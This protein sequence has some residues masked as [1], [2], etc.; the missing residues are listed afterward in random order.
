MKK[1][2]VLLLLLFPFLLIAQTTFTSTFTTDLSAYGEL[3][4]Y[5][6]EGEYQIFLS[7]DNILDKPIFLIDGFDPGDSRNITSIYNLLNFTGT[8]GSQNLADLLRAEGFD[9]V[10]L[11]F[12]TYIRMADGATIDGGADFMERNAMVLVELINIINTDKAANSPEQN[13]IIGPSMGGIIA[14]Y[15]LNYMENQSLDADTRLYISFDSPHYGANVPIGLQHQLNFLAYNETSAVAEIQPIINGL[16]NSP[17]AKQLL[18][19]HLEAHLS[20]V[21]L[22]TFN[23][24][25]TLPIAHPFRTVFETNINSLTPSGFPETTRNVSIINGSGINNSYFAVGNTGPTV[26][27]GYS[28]M[29][30]TLNVPIGIFT[31]DINIEVN[32]T[33]AAG[34]TN[35]ASSISIQLFS[36]EIDGSVANSE[37]FS[38][39]DGIDSAP[40]GLFDLSG[41]TGGIG[42]A[43]GIAEDFTNALNIDKFNF[44]P[45]ISALAIEFTDNEINWHHNINLTTDITPF[46]NI[47][48]PD[49]NEPHVQLT[50]GNVAFALMEILTPPLGISNENLMAFQLEKNPIQNRELVLLSNINTNANVSVIDVTGKTVFDTNTTL[51]NRTTIPVDLASG[52]YILSIASENN[53]TFVTKFFAN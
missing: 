40:G 39:S 14:R 35:T 15:A 51:N 11:N 6:G 32:F 37:A 33:P 3:T 9:V 27:N 10:V 36:T 43:G 16:L 44:I 22:V 26:T 1:N 53:R 17:A 42:G 29:N 41:I 23:P 2:Y 30:T 47:Y 50:A 20:G 8:S 34:T 46:D 31:A 49:D 24:T 12:P 25:L 13:V 4:S 48:V 52:L 18:T 28:V 5:P 45:S 7:A 38:Y 21:D 19:D